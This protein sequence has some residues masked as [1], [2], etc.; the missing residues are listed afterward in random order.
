[1]ESL[2]LPRPETSR[3]AFLR[4]AAQACLGVG[5]AVTGSSSWASAG[6]PRNAVIYIY[7]SGGMSQIDTFDTK[8]G[9][10]EQ[11]PVETIKT[12]IP[13]VGISEHLPRLAQRLH[14]WAVIRSMTTNQG[15]HVPA[16]EYLHTSYVN[17]GGTRLPSLAAWSAKCFPHDTRSLNGAAAIN[18]YSGYPFA[19]CLDPE[20]AP[21]AIQDPNAGLQDSTRSPGLSEPDFAESWT[22]ARELASPFQ[23]RWQNRDVQAYAKLYDQAV[24]LMPSS[25]L[26]AFDIAREPQAMHEQYGADKFGQ[27]CLLARRLIEHGFHFVEVVFPG[28]DTHTD[29]FSKSRE[30]SKTLDTSLSA[31]TDDLQDRGLWDTTLVVVGTEFGRTPGIGDLLGGRDHHVQAFSCLLGG[32][33]IRGGLVHGKTDKRSHEVTEDPVQIPELNAT[34]AHVLGIPKNIAVRLPNR[35]TPLR[36]SADAQYVSELVRE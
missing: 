27:G 25:E 11:G 18:P 26:A 30:L 35:A 24:R 29:H 10:P 1:M 13:G 8:P 17:E 7:L 6:K 5:A 32:G 12:S 21:L 2:V 16:R 20:F 9:S 14:H 31:L 36:P 28:W 15:D 4:T 33:P 23:A 22:L 19:G 3:R 34:I